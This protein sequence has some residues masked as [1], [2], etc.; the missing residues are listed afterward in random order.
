MRGMTQPPR[1]DPR[2]RADPD[3]QCVSKHI[4]RTPTWGPSKLTA[5]ADSVQALAEYIREHRLGGL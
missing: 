3:E 1:G 4:L 2:S 5:A